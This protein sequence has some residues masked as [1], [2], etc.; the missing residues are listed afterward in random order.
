M[1]ELASSELNRPAG[2]GGVWGTVRSFVSVR[3][4]FKCWRRGKSLAPLTLLNW[5]Q[6]L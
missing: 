5:W 1:G 4:V 2:W 6:R 3:L